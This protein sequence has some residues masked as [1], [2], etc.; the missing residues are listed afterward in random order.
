MVSVALYI[1]RLPLVLSRGKRFDSVAVCVDRHSRWIVAV[2][3]LNKGLL[4]AFVAQKML[5]W[6]WRPFE[7]P[8]VI[9][10]D[11]ASLFVG[12]W[13][14]NLCAGMGIWQ[15]FSQAYHHQANGRAECAGQS[16]MGILRKI[17]EE[18]KINWVEAWPQTVDRYHDVSNLSGLSPYQIVFGRHRPLGNVPYTPSSQCEDARDFFT[19]MKEI[20]LA[21]SQKVEELHA[22]VEAKMASQLKSSLVFHVGDL[23]WYRQPE[24]SGHKIDTRW[25]GKA[26]V[27]AR[28]SESSYVIEIRPVLN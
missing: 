2:L 27:I 20:D 16:L 4:C 17:Y 18:K 9:K 3:C 15:A 10:S 14:E 8:S 22:R 12:S 24:R 19:R 26:L 28:E 13:F 7:V 23:V 21:V 6:Q 25:L 5:K 11:Q 1:F